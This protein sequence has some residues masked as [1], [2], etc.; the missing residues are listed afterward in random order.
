MEFGGMTM[1]QDCLILFRS[2]TYAQRAAYVLERSGITAT[3]RKAPPGLTDRGCTYSVRLRGQHLGNALSL[4]R[5]KGLE[6]GKVFM[7]QPEG[8][9]Q[10]VGP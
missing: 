1:Q 10:E 3:V 2:L 8:G 7:I 6:R 9:F 4:L 5:R